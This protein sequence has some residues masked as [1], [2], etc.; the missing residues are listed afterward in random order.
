[1]NVKGGTSYERKLNEATRSFEQWFRNSI[2]RELVTID[3]IEQYA[4]FQDQNQNNN[5][6]LS[7]DKYMIV[8]KGSNMKVGSYVGWRKTTWMVFTDEYKTINTHKQAKV[9]ESNHVMKWMVKN[10]VCGNGMGYPA[11]IQNQTLYTLGVST[12]GSHAWIVNAKMMMYMQDNSESRSIRIGQRI[13]IGGEVYQVMFKDYVSRSGLINFLLEQDFV[14]LE[15]DNV[16]LG[17]A[18]YYTAENSDSTQEEP[19][20]ISKEIIISGSDKARIGTLATYEASVFQDGTKVSED[21]T[22]WVIADTESVATVVEQTSTSI[23]I[24]IESNFQKVGSVIN[25]IGKTAD[26]TIG[27][28][29]VNITS[30]Y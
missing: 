14:N 30:P 25:I 3:G 18:D 4:V 23:T 21:I 15:R 13:F 7:D 9:K 8:E 27:S 24:R 29:S 5:K 17:I 22:E 19:A 12:S 16:E 1:M 20:G 11:F 2:G 26:G 10:K 28:K 6:D